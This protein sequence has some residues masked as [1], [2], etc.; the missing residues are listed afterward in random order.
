MHDQLPEDLLEAEVNAIC[1]RYRATP[2]QAR[3]ALIEAL[4]AAPGLAKAVQ[5]RKDVTRLRAYKDAVKAARKQVYYEL[6]QYR[7]GA[8]AGISSAAQLEAQVH[9]GAALAEVQP[10]VQALLQ[11]HSSTAERDAAAFY[12]ALFDLVEPP[13]TVLDVGCGV[14]PLTYPFGALPTSLYM[15]LDRDAEAIRAL[16]AFAALVEPARLV[17]VQ[18]DLTGFDWTQVQQHAHT[19]DLA[20]MLKLVP[21]VRRQHRDQLA[22]LAQAPAR[23]ILVT[24]NV[25]S[26]TRREDIRARE[27]K[28]LR[29]FISQAARQIVD[30]FETPGEFGYLL[31]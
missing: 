23:Q 31:A 10:T 4:A 5:A 19:F 3:A 2:E 24:G 16:E 21:V 26:L 27:D 6:R 29:A 7:R 1:K 12:R 14:H 17:P 30:R 11:G 22:F 28:A 18:A 9:A 13:T 8:D 25:H 20:L 15:A